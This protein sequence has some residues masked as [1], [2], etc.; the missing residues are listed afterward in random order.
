[1]IYNI[2]EISCLNC[3]QQSIEDE[4]D[5]NANYDE[6]EIIFGPLSKRKK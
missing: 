5:D 3:E 1:M 2:T 4:F 6:D